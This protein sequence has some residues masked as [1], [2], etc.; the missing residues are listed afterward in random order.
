VTTEIDTDA[1]TLIGLFEVPQHYPGPRK[2]K[3]ATVFKW[4]SHGL[5]IQG[6]TDRVKLASVKLNGIR[7]TSVEA[8]SRFVRA[9]N[10]SFHQARRAE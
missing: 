4:V 6:T 8:L 10:G 2:P 7:Y 1:E 9:A 3:R 5:Q